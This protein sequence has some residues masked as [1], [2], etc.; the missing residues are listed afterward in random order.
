MKEPTGECVRVRRIT[1]DERLDEGLLKIAVA[2]LLPGHADLSNDPL[3]AWSDERLELINR[4]DYMCSFGLSKGDPLLGV[5]VDEPASES[6]ERDPEGTFWRSLE[7]GQVY[8][9]GEIAVE[10]A[11]STSSI[12]IFAGRGEHTVLRI[13]RIEDIKKKHEEL[14]SKA[15]LS[16]S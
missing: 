1:I 8:L 7:E 13:D 14:Y 2:D 12:G 3:D 16:R 4:E 9:V 10:E 11:E 6:A 5:L 15:L